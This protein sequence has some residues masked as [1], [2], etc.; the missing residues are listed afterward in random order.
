MRTRGTGAQGHG[1]TAWP[2]V[3]AALVLALLSG[4]GGDTPTEWETPPERPLPA[5]MLRGA[6][7]S[8]LERIE[9][10]GGVFRDAGRAGDAIAILRAH[11]ANAFR[12]RL[13]VNPDHTE[14]QVNDL[15]YTV[16][17]AVRIKAAGAKLLLDFHYSDTW[18]DPGRQT[19]PSAWAA[20]PFDS[21]EHQVEVYSADVIARLKQAGALPDIVQVGNEVDAG[22]LWPLGRVGG[23][24]DT[25]AQWDRFTRL[26][27][28]GIRGVR[29]ALG[30][31]DTVRIL[32]HYSQ[33]ASSGGTQWF[34]DHLDTYGVPYDIIGL[35][36]Y[37][38]WHGQP[39]YLRN[40]LDATVL[41]YGRDVMVVETT[42]PWR[43]GGV[44]A[45]APY[46]AA[47]AWPVS[48][49]GQARFL[50]DVLDAVAALPGGR[51]AG[52][53]WWYP[54]AIDVSGLFVWG[55]GSL[56]LFDAGGNLLPAA[57]AFGR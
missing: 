44:D 6:D 48:P 5:G 46:A 9:Q 37:P 24:D 12:L 39:A 36:Y 21:L 22:M 10:A 47:L 52:V 28:A 42:F 50:N 4:C 11:G 3:G 26:L 56:A 40:N 33:G 15:D 16:R 35:S 20:L 29:S 23:S 13:F 14:V 7:I 32:L 31:A 1:G 53:L 2:C 27:K 54:E 43:A 17:M 18:A 30:P 51:G 19:T 34:F 25:P 8:A 38:W 57:A 45:S 41:R 55:G 49:Q